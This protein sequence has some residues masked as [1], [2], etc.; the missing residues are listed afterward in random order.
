MSRMD[1]VTLEPC[2]GCERGGLHTIWAESLGVGVWWVPS[3]QSSAQGSGPQARRVD[4]V[5]AE[6]GVSAGHWGIRAC[7]L[8]KAVSIP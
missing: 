8:K 4:E 3:G 1:S 2:S 5:F 7:A 6:C